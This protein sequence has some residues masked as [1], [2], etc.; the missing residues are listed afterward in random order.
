[1]SDRAAAVL[2]QALN[3]SRRGPG[4][5]PDLGDGEWERVF[6]LASDAGMLPRLHQFL[7]S[8]GRP[9]A[10]IQARLRALVHANLARSQRLRR[11]AIVAAAGLQEQGIPCCLLKGAALAEVLTPGDWSA[12]FSAD[13]DLLVPAGEQERAWRLVRDMGGVPVTQAE[14]PHHHLP[15]L[16]LD[17]CPIEVHHALCRPSL[18][19]HLDAK[20]AYAR[21]VRAAPG[22]PLWVL[23]PADQLVHL[24][25][26]LAGSHGFGHGLRG[27]YDVGTAVRMLGDRIDWEEVLAVARACGG[28]PYIYHALRASAELLAAPVP[29]GVLRQLARES[30]E[31]PLGRWLASRA[32]RWQLLPWRWNRRHVPDHFANYLCFS[33][34]APMRSW[35]R[36]RRVLTLI[37]V[38]VNWSASEPQPLPAPRFLPYPVWL[39]LRP[40]LLTLRYLGRVAGLLPSPRG[41][42]ARA[43]RTHHRPPHAHAPMKAASGRSPS[44]RE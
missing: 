26:H 22:S 16:F 4:G 32:A 18:G 19:V 2:L 34:V 7:Q 28:Q 27:L 40:G 6:K 38:P 15:A 41:P 24:C 17:G 37:F 1:M 35:A 10:R 12:R 21:R 3:C 23:A 9:P 20:A 39:S 29:A 25:L 30:G 36:L 33:L 8:D 42:G 14:Q 13:L 44:A 5:L 31:G 43:K 11:V